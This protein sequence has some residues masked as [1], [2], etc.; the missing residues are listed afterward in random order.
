MLKIGQK[1]LYFNILPHKALPGT[2]NPN[3]INVVDI[4]KY[5][6]RK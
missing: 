3:G 2:G 6:E 1:R 5:D 4:I